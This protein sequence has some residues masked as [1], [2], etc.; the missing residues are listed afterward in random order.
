MEEETT[1]RFWYV[2]LILLLAIAAAACGQ[3]PQASTPQATE[4]P[5]V[6]EAQSEEPT[7][8][9]DTPAPE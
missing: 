2:A 9:A 1:K 6:D 3:I 7:E 8:V 5:A 4:A